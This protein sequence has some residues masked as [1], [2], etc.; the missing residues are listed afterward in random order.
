MPANEPSL[1]SFA[2]YVV[3]T[4]IVPGTPTFAKSW[5]KQVAGSVFPRSLH[6]S[7]ALKFHH[8]ASVTYPAGRSDATKSKPEGQ[9]SV[10]TS[11]GKL[12]S[13]LFALVENSKCFD[14]V[15]S[16]GQMYG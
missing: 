9:T 11:I 16:Y 15:R 12:G 10:A 14:R 5:A 8:V 2:S 7:T 6:T 13:G 4:L 3:R 1:V